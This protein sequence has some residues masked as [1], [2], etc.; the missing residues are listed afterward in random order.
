MADIT[1][2]VRY[3]LPVA[4]TETW[5]SLAE[6]GDTETFVGK[7]S[8]ISPFKQYLSD[9]I[10]RMLQGEANFQAK[11]DIDVA[12]ASDFCQAN[13]GIGFDKVIQA[14]MKFAGRPFGDAIVYAVAEAA[15]LQVYVSMLETVET[16]HGKDHALYILLKQKC[17]KKAP[18]V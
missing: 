18:K 17:L 6:R 16:R 7:S 13:Y 2:T 1:P 10:S 3:I 11:I 14:I 12:M 15:T 5:L 8:V 4:Y 9:S